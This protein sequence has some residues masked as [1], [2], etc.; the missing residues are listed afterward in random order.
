MTNDSSL[1]QTLPTRNVFCFNL[2]HHV[3]LT[4][5]GNIDVW[6]NHGSIDPIYSVQC[7]E[8]ITAF[9]VAGNSPIISSLHGNNITTQSIRTNNGEFQHVDVLEMEESVGCIYN[10]YFINADHN[11]CRYLQSKRFVR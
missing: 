6:K 10:F 7:K 11:V 1:D 2:V 5:A 9:S 4:F 8:Q 3:L